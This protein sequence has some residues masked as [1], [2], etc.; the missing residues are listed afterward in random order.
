MA[1]EAYGRPASSTTRRARESAWCVAL[2]LAAA[3]WFCWLASA[4]SSSGTITGEEAS[5]SLRD[6]LAILLRWQPSVWSTNVGGAAFYGLAGWLHP[7]PGLLSM[8]PAKALATA[9]L[10]PLVYLVAR[11]RLG[12]ERPAAVAGAA[13]VALLPGVSTMAWVAIETPLDTV[14]GAAALFVVTS[15]RRWWPTGLLLA[16]LSVS[17][18]TAGLAWAAVVLLVA[19]ARVRSFRAAGAVTAAVAGGTAVVAWP[20]AWWL[21]GGVIVTGGGHGGPDLGALPGHLAELG[22]YLAI[23]GSSYYYFSDAPMLGHWWLAALVAGA[24]VASAAAR[25]RVLWPW[26]VLG[27]ASCGLYAVSSGVPGSR[28]VVALCVVAALAVAVAL[29]TLGAVVPIEGQPTYRVM[30]A[31]AAVVL[32]AAATVPSAV[33][34]RADMLDGARALPHDWPLHPD[35]S[36]PTATVDRLDADLRTGRVTVG[37]V[38]E[39]HG[40]TRILAMVWVLHK[41]DPSPPFPVGEIVEA[42]WRSG[43]RCSL[44]GGC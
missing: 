24:V 13:G 41:H 17:I 23:D 36:G 40:G 44:D 27:L 19:L 6:P 4:A 20:L 22:R 12:C 16:G 18:Y 1:T 37:E 11:R 21:N 28:R 14:A 33:A 15:H 32:V 25:W 3:A 43:D 42:Y 31:V 9:L 29:D 2:W 34:W 8:R 38:A 5:I 39:Q 7:D 26:L 30:S 10:A 35:P